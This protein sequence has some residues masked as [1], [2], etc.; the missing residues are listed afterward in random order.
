MKLEF[1]EIWSW[2]LQLKFGFV[3]K[4]LENFESKISANCKA[5]ICGTFETKNFWLALKYFE[6]EILFLTIQI[7]LHNFVFSSLHS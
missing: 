1:E 4:I 7:Y 6:L 5:K 3:A 2:N